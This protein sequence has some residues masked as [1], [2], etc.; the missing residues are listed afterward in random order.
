MNKHSAL[1]YAR[2]VL[3]AQDSIAL[4]YQN[5][6]KELKEAI[7]IW[8]LSYQQNQSSQDFGVIQQSHKKRLIKILNDLVLVTVSVLAK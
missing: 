1:G 8:K 2:A 3:F 6:I 4:V 5:R 7:T